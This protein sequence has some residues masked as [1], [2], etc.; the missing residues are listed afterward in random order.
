VT[1]VACGKQR[2]HINS[3]LP[4]IS[5]V[6]SVTFFLALSGILCSTE[7]TVSALV[8]ATIATM[9]PFLPFAALLVRMV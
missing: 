6:T 5:R 8:P 7:M 4:A 3:I 2:L 9:A 1:L